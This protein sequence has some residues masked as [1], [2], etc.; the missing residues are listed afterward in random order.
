MVSDMDF[1]RARSRLR[2]QTTQQR[3]GNPEC[4]TPVGDRSEGEKQGAPRGTARGLA[5]VGADTEAAVLAHKPKVT[6]RTEHPA[7]HGN[8]IEGFGALR[9]TKMEMP[10]KTDNR[11]NSAVME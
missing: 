6:V 7:R 10:E 1:L 11:S 5:A 8:P 2:G 3:I 4:E 9:E